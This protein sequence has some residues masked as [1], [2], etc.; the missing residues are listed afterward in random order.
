MLPAK[1]RFL[2]PYLH[3][4]GLLL[5]VAGLPFSL[6]LMSLSQFFIGGNWILEGNF[7][8]KWN[9]F[10]H[11]KRALLMCGIL[12]MLLPGMLY[13]YNI[14]EGLKLIRLNLPFLIFPFVL[15]SSPQLKISWYKL[16][17]KLGIVS[18][19]LATLSCAIIGL[20]RWLDG[21][22]SDIRQI[23]L[24]ISHIRFSLLIV[25]SVLLI[26]WMFTQK[27]SWL[28]P[29]EKIIAVCMAVWLLVF[30][31]I[32]QS[33]TGLIILVLVSGAWIILE[34]W[35]RLKPA[36]ALTVY[37]LTL[38][39]FTGL[40]ALVVNAYENYITP[41]EEYYKPKPLLT[42]NGNPYSHNYTIIENS[43]FV[44]ANVCR[45]ELRS[46]WQQRTPYPIDSIDGKSNPVYITLVRFLNSKGLR[47]D[48]EGVNALSDHEIRYIQQGIANV[49]YTGLWGIRMRFYQLL[50]EVNYYRRDGA[51]ASG[52]SLLMKLEF[53]RNAAQIIKSYPIAGVGIGDVSDAFKLQ[54]STSKTWLD[55]TWWM[56]SHNQF[57]YIGVAAGI[58]GLIVFLICFFV[59]AFK[60]ETR[61]HVPFILF[62]SIALISMLTEDT[63]TTQAGVSFV[64]FYYSLFLFSRPKITSES[65][66]SSGSS[67]LASENPFPASTRT[68]SPRGGR[69]V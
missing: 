32:L 64:A 40:V 62:F 5:M 16:L 51:N 37:A 26:S 48:A 45:T 21:S 11:D 58:P 65:E 2:H 56:N 60:R 7:L 61:Y 46:A 47:K 10:R 34:L 54:Y 43:H 20:P 13:S 59:P 38:L 8:V 53:W 68:I 3:Y 9:R 22:L 1:L 23:S 14:D 6:L 25:F 17:I 29:V 44:F 57:L 15:S 50:W 27:N 12:L 35:R 67:L 31:F 30:L 39:V 4:T 36:V 24:F 55:K 19:F 69:D 41:A 49:N 63:L 18:V 42:K 28:A 33:L 52:H 66:S